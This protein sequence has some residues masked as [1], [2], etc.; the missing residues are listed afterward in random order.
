M[1]ERKNLADKMARGVSSFFEDQLF[2]V[3]FLTCFQFH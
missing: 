1:V 3:D 2:V